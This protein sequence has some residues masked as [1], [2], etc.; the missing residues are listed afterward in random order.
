MP[1]LSQVVS[2][3]GQG[4]VAARYEPTAPTRQATAV[5]TSRAA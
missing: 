1:K 4:D 5:P 2:V 3:S